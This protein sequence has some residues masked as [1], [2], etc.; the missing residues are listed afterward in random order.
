MECAVSG[1]KSGLPNPQNRHASTHHTDT[2]TLD[3]RSA[4]VRS[5]RRSSPYLV[6]SYMHAV[7]HPGCRP[8]V[9]PLVTHHLA[10]HVIDIRMCPAKKRLGSMCEVDP[11]YLPG[12]TTTS[13]STGRSAG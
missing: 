4:P 6:R 7:Q 9:R 2:G 1:L 5:T 13:R 8:S 12:S 11:L 3:I 10:M